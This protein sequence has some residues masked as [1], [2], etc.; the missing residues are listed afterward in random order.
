MVIKVT[1][2]LQ[3]LKSILVLVCDFC[4]SSHAGVSYN[5][6]L[7]CHRIS[8]QPEGMMPNH[9]YAVRLPLIK[10]DAS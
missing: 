6:F 1:L 2:K 8:E 5:D 4:M 9:R 10:Y 7:V 3:G